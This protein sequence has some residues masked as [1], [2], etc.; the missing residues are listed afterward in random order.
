MSSNW[1][2][3]LALERRFIDNNQHAILKYE[4]SVKKRMYAHSAFE[5]N[6]G[7][8]DVESLSGTNLDRFGKKD[9]R[10]T[11]TDI[12]GDELDVHFYGCRVRKNCEYRDF[13][14]SDKEREVFIK[15]CKQITHFI[16]RFVDFKE[17]TL[18]YYILD[19]LGMVKKGLLYQMEKKKIHDTDEEFYYLSFETL[20]KN[21]LI[22]FKH[23]S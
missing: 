10:V 11:W 12:Y 15:R 16:Y 7:G 17:Q 21:G 5:A 8:I 13:T 14:T 20:E 23:K 2:R 9:F 3:N 1:H 6:T 18:D 22:L 19:L 4:K